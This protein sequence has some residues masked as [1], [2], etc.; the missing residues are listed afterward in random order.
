MF[1]GK[2]KSCGLQ[3]SDD[4]LIVG[5]ALVYMEAFDRSLGVRT[6]V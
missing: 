6:H 3:W 4:D 2:E 5:Q 1:K